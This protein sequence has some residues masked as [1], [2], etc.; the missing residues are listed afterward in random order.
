MWEYQYSVAVQTVRCWIMS[1]GR[2]L[3]IQM[4][5]VGRFRW[6]PLH[7]LSNHHW[8]NS[9]IEIS[10]LLGS[11]RQGRVF[12]TCKCSS[13]ITGVREGLHQRL[14]KKN[15]KIICWLCF[16]CLLPSA[17]PFLE[18]SAENS[19]R[20]KWHWWDWRQRTETMKTCAVKT[21]RLL[22]L[23]LIDALKDGHRIL[24]LRLRGGSGR[25]N[26]GRLCLCCLN[27]N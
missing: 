4:K 6:Q 22:W 25:H 17:R 2:V 9:L 7:T 10:L 11:T 12:Y 20:P 14:R 18:L 8:K 23:C 26:L 13:C 3:T 19:C 15:K 16:V 21:E 24:K 27:V 5:D 1:L